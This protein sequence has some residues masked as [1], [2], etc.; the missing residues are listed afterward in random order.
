MVFRTLSDF[1]YI[2]PYASSSHFSLCGLSYTAVWAGVLGGGGLY[3]FL[4]NMSIW[5][6]L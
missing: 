4:Y 2:S 1:V 3:F 6:D 5:T